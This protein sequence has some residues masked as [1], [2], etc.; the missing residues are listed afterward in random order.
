MSLESEDSD[1]LCSD[2]GKKLVANCDRRHI[3]MSLV[4]TKLQTQQVM[5]LPKFLRI[6]WTLLLPL[7]VLC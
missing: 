3:L 6:E 4:V 1:K 5:M 2:H 7:L